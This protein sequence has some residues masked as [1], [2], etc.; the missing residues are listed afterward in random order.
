[1]RCPIYTETE[2]EKDLQNQEVISYRRPPLERCEGMRSAHPS[3]EDSNP[4]KQQWTKQD[5]LWRI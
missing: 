1:V 5:E 2:D 3:H 4:V